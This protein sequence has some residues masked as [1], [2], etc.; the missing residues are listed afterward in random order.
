MDTPV[1]PFLPQVTRIPIMGPSPFNTLVAVSVSA[2]PGFLYL[3]D[4][5][6]KTQS[7]PFTIFTPF[8]LAGFDQRVPPSFHHATAACVDRF[9]LFH[10]S[11]WMVAVDSVLGAGFDPTSGTFFVNV[12]FNHEHS[13]P[14]WPDCFDLLGQTACPLPV[15]VAVTSYVLCFEPPP[16]VG[17]SG[18]AANTHVRPIG[19]DPAESLSHRLL[20]ALGVSVALSPSGQGDF[21]RRPCKCSASTDVHQQS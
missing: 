11:D 19:R 5:F 3:A 4:D 17:Q 13:D 12:Q 10:D 6:G 21:A 20:R 15:F 9:G 7:F 1:T 18:S 14:Y 16:P 8:V 2:E